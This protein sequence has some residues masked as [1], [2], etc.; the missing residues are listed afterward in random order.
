MEVWPQGHCITEL[1]IIWCC[2]S[3]SCSTTGTRLSLKA[4]APARHD[5]EAT[6]SGGGGQLQCSVFPIVLLLPCCRKCNEPLR[7]SHLQSGDHSTF[8]QMIIFFRRQLRKERK[9]FAGKSI[10]S[11]PPFQSCDI[12]IGCSI[13]LEKQ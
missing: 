9:S 13:L 6:G 5:G 3:C 12:L 7:S 11:W 8:G 1:A 4:V 10:S 2:S